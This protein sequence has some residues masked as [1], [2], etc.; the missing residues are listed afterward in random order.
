MIDP[1]TELLIDAGFELVETGG[2]CTAL[3]ALD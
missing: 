2:G 3:G 1:F